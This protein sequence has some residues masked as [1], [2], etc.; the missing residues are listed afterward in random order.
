MATD[1][2][3]YSDIVRLVDAFY[4]RVRDDDVLGP[5]FSDVARVGWATHLPK[6]YNFWAS[7]LFGAGDFKGNPMLVHRELARRVPLTHVE[8]D[9][10][11]SV[12]RDTVDGLFAGPH[13]EDAKNRAARIAITM[14]HHIRMDD[15]HLVLAAVQTN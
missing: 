10:W 2:T 12:F 11:L 6:M 15:G 7:I 14:Q 4:D 1:V 9:R 5:I 13:A 8:F 3:T